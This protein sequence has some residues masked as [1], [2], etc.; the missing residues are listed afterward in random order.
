MVGDFR[1]ESEW[2]EIALGLSRRVRE[3]RVELYGEHGGPLLASAL[4]VPFRTWASYE[5]GE[6]IPAETILRFL[7]A[8]RTDPHWLLTGEGL[9]FVSQR[10]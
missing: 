2:S 5:A 4:G 7:E 9:K 10:G 3:V 1:P 6:S 8:T